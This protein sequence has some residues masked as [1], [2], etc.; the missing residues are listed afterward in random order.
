MRIVTYNWT[1]KADPLT[2]DVLSADLY[3]TVEIVTGE[4]A[5]LI[6]QI[7]PIDFFGD[8][9]WVE[10]YRNK[11]DHNAKMVIDPVVR[12]TKIGDKRSSTSPKT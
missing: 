5:D 8:Y 4:V 6:Y 11:V 2:K 12:N 1:E 3:V 7:K 9:Y 10:N